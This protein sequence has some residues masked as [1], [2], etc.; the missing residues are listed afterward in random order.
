MV[1]SK[2]M[3]KCVSWSEERTTPVSSDKI[4]DGT[5][6]GSEIFASRSVVGVRQLPGKRFTDIDP[7]R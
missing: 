6:R 1:N 3:L 2:A 4:A 5:S 7:C